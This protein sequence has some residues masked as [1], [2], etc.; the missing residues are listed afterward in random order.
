MRKRAFTLI[1][2]LVVIAIIALLISILLPSLGQAKEMA[3]RVKCLANLRSFSTITREF[4]MDHNGRVP[5]G[6]QCFWFDGPSWVGWMYG[7]DFAELSTTYG[8]EK[9]FHCPSRDPSVPYI[10]STRGG[11]PPDRTNWN[12]PGQPG[13]AA[14]IAHV[15]SLVAANTLQRDPDPKSAWWT[16]GIDLNTYAT[17]VETD[18][19]Y[20]GRNY[21]RNSSEFETGQ[22]HAWQI[23][24]VDSRTYMQSID[25]GQNVWTL[26]DDSNPVV[27]TDRN[28]Y[29]GWS[30]SNHGRNWRVTSVTPVVPNGDTAR[31]W[32]RT[33]QS[34]SGLTNV[35][36][37]DGHA[38]TKKIDL[39]MFSW[40]GYTGWLH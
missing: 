1:E 18:Y 37:M 9:L 5:A 2:L 25:N 29:Q 34:G 31:E 33:T 12:D 11:G 13:E 35:A 17:Y 27:M 28:V 36:Y 10:L 30:S 32:A 22:G 20:F 6:Q 3:R 21:A 14:Y 7:A 26:N 4:A 23:S 16:N 38:E 15:Q 19:L 39:F 40:D 24:K 8:A